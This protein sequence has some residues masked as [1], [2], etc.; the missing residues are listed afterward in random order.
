MDPALRLGAERDERPVSS[1]W[2]TPI[3]LSGIDGYLLGPL[4]TDP[5]FRGRGAARMLVSE[6]TDR[7]LTRGEGRFVLLVGDYPYYGPLGFERT[8]SGAIVFPG[9]VDPERVLA[10]APDPGLISELRGQVAAF[11]AR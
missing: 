8:R 2:M 6:V 11:G 3:S 4:A 1:V 9:P 10:H 5:A 7:A